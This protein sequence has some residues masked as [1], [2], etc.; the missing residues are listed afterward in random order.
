[1]VVR[2]ARL[3]A[4]TYAMLEAVT[5]VMEHLEDAGD[6]LSN[7]FG[8]YQLGRRRPGGSIGGSA[9]GSGGLLAGGAAMPQLM[10]GVLHFLNRWRLGR[11]RFQQLMLQR[12][13]LTALLEEGDGRDH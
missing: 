5:E 10:K 4:E 13:S 1:M 11:Q 12:Q 8:A 2:E 6:A 3:R 9:S 7:G